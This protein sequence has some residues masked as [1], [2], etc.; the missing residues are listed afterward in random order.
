M[1][2]KGLLA[3]LLLGVVYVDGV[4]VNEEMVRLGHVENHGA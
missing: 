4:D 2:G 3:T 1:K